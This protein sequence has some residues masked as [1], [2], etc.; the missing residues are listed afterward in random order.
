MNAKETLRDLLNKE[1]G[2]D[3]IDQASFDWFDE[4][5]EFYDPYQPRIVL[6]NKENSTLIARQ[7][8]RGAKL[9][10]GETLTINFDVDAHNMHTEPKNL[11]NETQPN[12]PKPQ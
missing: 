12:K 3:N 7:T 2:E 5:V 6:A 8:L 4:L 9:N 10:N 11:P 1:F